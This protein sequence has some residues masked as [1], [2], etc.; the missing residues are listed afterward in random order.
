VA[1]SE[2]AAPPAEN[3][4]ATAQT[5]L[6]LRDVFGF[7]DP[8]A[9]QTNRGGLS[10]STDHTQGLRS[11]AVTATGYT[12]ITSIPLRSLRMGPVRT[13]SFDVKI[14][15]TQVNPWWYGDTHLFVSA[16]S[17][18]IYNQYMGRHDL[19]DLNPGQYGNFQFQ[20][21]SDISE[22]LAGDY[23]D[24][25]FKIVLNVPA[26]NGAYLLDNLRING[27]MPGD[28]ALSTCPAHVAVLPKGALRYEL[29]SAKRYSAIQLYVRQNG[30]ESVRA[31]SEVPL[32]N[33]TYLYAVVEP[34]G[35]Y[36]EGDSLALRFRGTVAGSDAETF[37]PGP[38][39]DAFT[40]TFAYS[41]NLR[42]NPVNDRD[43]DGTPDQDDAC[44]DDPTKTTRGLCGCGTPETD[45][46]A[47]GVPDCSDRCADDPKKFEPGDCGCAGAP[48]PA[49]YPC[50]DG[51]C[52]TEATC[53]G[54]GACGSADA[55]R[56]DG[57][58][59]PITT[60]AYGNY[61]Y[62]IV[63]PMSWDEISQRAADGY[64]RFEPADA[65]EAELV[66]RQ[67]E[68]HAGAAAE[69]WTS[70][71]VDGGERIVSVTEDGAQTKVIWENGAAVDGAY[72]PWADGEPRFG[73]G[74]GCV[75]LG[76][77][78]KARLA[79]CGERRTVVIKRQRFSLK[80]R[81]TIP[82]VTCAD[83]PGLRCPAS[84]LETGCVTSDELLG[85][86]AEEIA[87]RASAC[88]ACQKQPGAD[89][90]AKC[91]GFAAPPATGSTCAPTQAS[92]GSF[93]RVTEPEAGECQ[94]N[95]DC[96]VP[97][98]VCGIW[99]ACVGCEDKLLSATQRRCGKPDPQCESQDDAEP[100]SET[101]LCPEPEA[102]GDANPFSPENT[103]GSDLS[104]TVFDAAATFTT[105]PA[106]Q[107][108]HDTI[109]PWAAEPGQAHPW[110]KYG[111]T[112]L[113]QQ[114]ASE[115]KRGKAG[116]SS[117][118]E[119]TFD[120][121][122]SL[123]Y[124]MS[125]LPQGELN[126]D[127]DAIASLRSDARVTLLGSTT[128]VKLINA[129]IAARGNRCRFRTSD[130]KFEVFGLD[131][132]PDLL[133]GLYY[134]SWS[135]N[136]ERTRQCLGALDGLQEVGDRAKKAL[137]DLEELLRQYHDALARG[138]CF[139]AEGVCRRLLANAPEDFPR[140]SCDGIRFEDL[141][142]LF[143]LHY[144]RQIEFNRPA[145]PEL[146]EIPSLGT[147][148]F[149]NPRFKSL[150]LP[151]PS[152]PAVSLPNLGDLSVPSLPDFSSAGSAAAAYTP[153]DRD[154]PMGLGCT[155]STIKT[156]RQSLVAVNFA[157]GPIP[158]LLEMEGVLKYGI[159]GDVSYDF[160]PY[161]L[162]ADEQK[163][164]IAEVLAEAEPCASAGVG[165][166]V[167][168]G[169]SA[170]GFKAA[171]GVEGMVNL[172]TLSLPA[173]AAATLSGSVEPVN[174]KS[175]LLS[176]GVE[177]NEASRYIPEELEGLWS[178]EAFPLKRYRFY[179]G[180]EYGAS[181][182]ATEI[183]NGSLAASLRIKFWRFSRRW[184]RTLATFKNNLSFEKTLIHGGDDFAADG[185]FPW[186]TVEMPNAFPK[187]RRLHHVPSEL[188]GN[189]VDFDLL[190]GI[191][192]SGLRVPD[193]ARLGFG[194]P[195]LTQLDV[196]RAQL[197]DLSR[198]LSMP[199]LELR[200]S[201]NGKDLDRL[202]LADFSGLGL[203]LPDF[204]DFGLSLGHLKALHLNWSQVVKLGI[205][206]SGA[207]YRGGNGPVSCNLDL[208]LERVGDFFYE[209]A[210]ACVPEFNAQP[211]YRG[212]QRCFNNGDCCDDAPYC[213]PNAA[214]GYGVCS[215]TPLRTLDR[216][217]K[218]TANARVF[219]RLEERFAE[220]FER[221][222]KQ[223]WLLAG[224]TFDDEGFVAKSET[225]STNIRNGWCSDGGVRG[226]ITILTEDMDITSLVTRSADRKSVSFS[227]GAQDRCG[228]AT[229]Y[230]ARVRFEFD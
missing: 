226:R 168:A 198:L 7:E 150:K 102:V 197:P 76:A 156:R 32:A 116:A 16:P 178:G 83:F 157:L 227:L 199:D 114:D 39:P 200:L 38:G 36:A 70:G 89:C 210:C 37:V 132:L 78:G 120:P 61:V 101:L 79:G 122:V 151:N 169:F 43:A 161:A 212:Q 21:R 81:T 130:S 189:P 191:D 67:V 103:A 44:P 223:V 109:E 2:A 13:V 230:D 84:D 147:P 107:E 194:L 77:D 53:D 94:S 115:T 211:P 177:A 68:R 80:A 105:T 153:E 106:P 111:V 8:Q 141:I 131:F 152:F 1:C 221:P 11:L 56:P 224:T 142:N 18:G 98:H 206:L 31:P 12:E 22:A 33:G 47:D 60:F 135:D 208:D 182:K 183:L 58:V 26:G 108:R 121:N 29:R 86:S 165:L 113:P 52:S 23:A 158:M 185:L 222:I 128:D 126:F 42:C 159:T 176:E 190:E 100:C 124:G 34:A 99:S 27:Q 229:A 133:P 149:P 96:S 213:V 187:F 19:H 50:K 140:L 55:C 112:P 35:T 175:A 49:G 28:T 174:V 5:G 69:I 154:L 25:T 172:A 40:S 162:Q 82:T 57:T 88:E 48:S 30:Q 202:K 59:G 92:T 216:E 62:Q 118:V 139:D 104:T 225:E 184:K 204:K 167:G 14:P 24:L 3:A 110:C 45:R 193:L 20:I 93:C 64:A 146:P 144:E 195:E 186:G 75:A 215:K 138:E 134:D 164:V 87:A 160:S 85:L 125:A 148:A 129:V 123:K 173:K 180:Y 214:A 17:L 166:F 9:W 10:T 41:S 66:R 137:R 181:V 171:V 51:G 207:S 228:T 46:D 119:L 6:S 90:T 95:R 71:R 91:T 73:S 192:I 65:V 201:R 205:N 145:F 4:V 163:H 72:L 136:P 218:A 196:P 179:L 170:Y 63:E 117:P 219:P 220:S 203:S 74:Q 217:F 127:L 54:H 188:L 209:H 97:G 155:G 15:T 143:N